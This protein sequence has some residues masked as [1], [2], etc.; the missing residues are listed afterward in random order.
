[1]QVLSIKLDLHECHKVS[2]YYMSTYGLQFR[3]S[4]LF[5]K[6]QFNVTVQRAVDQRSLHLEKSYSEIISHV[7]VRV[8][9]GVRGHISLHFDIYSVCVCWKLWA[10]KGVFWQSFHRGQLECGR[11]HTHQNTLRNTHPLW[12]LKLSKKSI[13]RVKY[14]FIKTIIAVKAYISPKKDLWPV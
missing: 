12:N 4:A 6:A 3:S 11:Y 8:T 10:L 2:L 5:F 9:A 7:T 13:N 1:M 14:E